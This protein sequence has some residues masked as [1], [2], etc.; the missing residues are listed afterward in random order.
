M[1]LGD[2]VHRRIVASTLA[3]IRGSLD[4]VKEGKLDE[5]IIHQLLLLSL[6][7]KFNLEPH[8]NQR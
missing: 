1:M 4:L 5:V 7:L 8:A 2:G 3:E 6:I